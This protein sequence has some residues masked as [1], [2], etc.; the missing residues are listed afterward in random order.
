V[1][2]GN[3]VIDLSKLQNRS[4]SMHETFYSESQVHDRSRSEFDL[5]QYSLSQGMGQL[6]TFSKQALKEGS[7]KKKLRKINMEKFFELGQ[8]LN[9]LADIDGQVSYFKHNANSAM[10]I[11]INNEMEKTDEEKYEIIKQQEQQENEMNEEENEKN[12][13]KIYRLPVY[14]K[15]SQMNL[16]NR[17][18]VDLINEKKVYRNFVQEVEI[19]AHKQM[20]EMRENNEVVNKKPIKTNDQRFFQK[21]FGTYV[22]V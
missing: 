18:I 4:S 15:K 6:P 1:S 16:Q 5:Y 11:Y 8:M 9:K 12:A 21:I 10:D 7:R 14:A 17:F 19:E 13:S 22:V 3:I 20:Y 2:K